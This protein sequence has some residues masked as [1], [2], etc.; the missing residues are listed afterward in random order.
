MKLV[1]ATRNRHKLRELRAL[2]YGS[3]FDLVPI[4]EVAPEAA[5]PEDEPTFEENALAKARAAAAATGMAA[6]ADDS[7]LEVDALCGAP[8]VRSARFAGEP[9]DDVRNNRKLLVAMRGI[10]AGRRTARYLCA[11]AFVDPGRGLELLRA[12]TCEGTVLEAPR[13]GGGFGYDPLFLVAA[14]GRSMAEIELEAK[15]AISHRAMAFRALRDALARD[16][17]L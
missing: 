14:L 1:L 8:G 5:L 7:G 9:C 3:G 11:A 13:G 17:V 6:V 2:L 15:H 12:G 4:D 16:K 10:P